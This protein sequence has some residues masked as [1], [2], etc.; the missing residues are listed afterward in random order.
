MS[1][2]R[3]NG[4]FGQILKYNDLEADLCTKLDLGEEQLQLIISFLASKG[5]CKLVDSS[6]KII[7]FD[8]CNATISE[9]EISLLRL[10]DAKVMI[11]QDID[12]IE[13]EIERCKEEAR[14]AIKQNNKSKGM[15]ILKKKARLNQQLERKHN[16][17]D[18]IETLEEQLLSTDTNKQILDVLA[19][20]TQVLKSKN[21]MPEDVDELLCSLEEAMESHKSLLHDISK[22]LGGQFVD[23]D[24]LEEELNQLIE[25]D[26]I[27]KIIGENVSTNNLKDLSK[28]VATT[29]SSKIELLTN[30]TPTT[31]QS[32]SCEDKSESDE[33]FERLRKLKSPPQQPVAS[34]QKNEK[35]RYALLDDDL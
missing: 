16:Q 29:K 5:N 30:N 3:E 1:Y 14:E 35:I 6:V 23:E 19:K 34:S 24:E 26:E 15:N 25:E 21:K 22:P 33:L 9:K 11:E 4:L 20:S 13:D 7:K 31:V 27:E 28:T 10:E 2:A 17:F 12:K 8:D 18:N 32:P